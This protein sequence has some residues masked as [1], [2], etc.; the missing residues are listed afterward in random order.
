MAKSRE[1]EHPRKAFGW[2]ARD[3]SGQPGIR[4][5]YSLPSNSL[6]GHLSLSLSQTSHLVCFIYILVL[7][8]SN[9]KC[10][11][12]LQGSMHHEEAQHASQQQGSLQ[13]NAIH[14]ASLYQKQN[15]EISLSDEDLEELLESIPYHDQI[16]HSIQGM[17]T[18]GCTR[19]IA[20]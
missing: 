8:K 3:S 15:R 10:Q 11:G 1:V 5:G 4:L 9:A 18:S 12:E 6:E 14:S 16:I 7:V 13:L 2:A 19:V 17:M 20:R